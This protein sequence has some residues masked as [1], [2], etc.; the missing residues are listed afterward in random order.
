MTST[1]MTKKQVAEVLIFLSDTYPR[2]E[3]TQSKIDTWYRLM[4]NQNPAVVMKNAEKYALTQKY[5]PSISELIERKT[6]ARNN[7]ILEKI[8][9]WERDAVDKPRS[10]TEP[11][12]EYFNKS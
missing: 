9:D 7:D 3:V 4:K 11:Y 6:D 1:S 12:R 10:R 8:K 2:F 5:P